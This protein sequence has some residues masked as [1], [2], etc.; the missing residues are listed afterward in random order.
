MTCI[1]FLEEVQLALQ[2]AGFSLV[3]CFFF[4]YILRICVEKGIQHGESMAWRQ[5]VDKALNILALSTW[6]NVEMLIS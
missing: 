4:F 2:N 3:Y 6:H 1:C 5:S